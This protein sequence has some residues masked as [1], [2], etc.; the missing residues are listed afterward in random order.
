[1]TASVGSAVT[2]DT[3]GGDIVGRDAVGRD[4]VGRDT[5][6]RGPTVGDPTSARSPHHITVV[7]PEGVVLEFR[8]AGVASRMLA[9]GLDFV[10]L[11][12]LLILVIFSAVVVAA[13][14][15]GTPAV[16]FAIVAL[17]AVFYG[18]PVAFEAFGGG[19]TIGKRAFGLRVI[20]VEGG[21]VGV[22]H[23]TI[24]ALLS[25]VDYWLPA[26][27]G[28]IALISA[29]VTNRSQRLGD[30][31]AGTIVI[32]EPSRTA[33]PY[34][35]GLVV[36][37]ERYGLNLD[38]SRLKPA[39]YALA[40]ELLVRSADLLPEARERLA[41]ELADHLAAETG[42]PRPSELSAERFLQSLLFAHQQ[43]ARATNGDGGASSGTG[44]PVMAT[45]PAA[46]MPPPGG[47][48]VHAGPLAAMAPPSGA[49]V[50][51]GPPPDAAPR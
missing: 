51:I 7:T 41:E 13:A 40:R 38:A 27:G 32:R 1:M 46:S 23:A 5:A 4:A 18:Y 43:Q 14:G 2:T 10:I 17:F 35:F 30:L 26:P 25:V 11:F 45:P 20:T 12:I 36:G 37:A 3:A 47:A 44:S 39:H 8:A 48:P 31:A 28:V 33:T 49:P 34:V 9:I 6:G 50:P 15:A 22:R 29:L 42:N 16:V 19:R 21:P 24:R